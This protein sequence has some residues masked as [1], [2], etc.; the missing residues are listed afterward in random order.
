MTLNKSYRIT[1]ILFLLMAWLSS[2]SAVLAQ[3]PDDGQNCW[4]CHRQPNLSGV[5]GTRAEIDQCLECHS[6][7]QVDEW[8]AEG[9][10]PVY[11]DTAHYADTLH[12]GIACTA[13][14]SDV[15]R[16]PHHAE[17]PV[18]CT[19]C[20]ATLLTH[21]QMGAPHASTDC[22]AC[23]WADLPAIQDSATGRVVVAGV[24]AEGVVLD[25]T[26]HAV[27]TDPDCDTCHV[28]GNS[29]GAPA[30][31][32]PAR[33]VICMACHDASPTVSVAGI[34]GAR[35]T[36]YGAIIGLLVFVVGMG[37]NFSIY[38]RGEIPG[39]PGLTVMQKLSYLA[40]EL[41]KLVFSRRVLRFIGGIIADGILLRRVLQESVSRWVMHALIYL[42][43][44]ARF[45]LGLLTWLGE[46]FW[47]A[48]AWTQTLANKDAPSVAF[49]YDFLALLVILGVLVALY[50]RFVVRVPQLRTGGQDKLA[51]FLLGALFLVGIITEG[52]RLL[53]AATPPDV[54]V[55]SFLGYGVA[56]LLRPLNL[57][58]TSV[59]PLLWYL[60]AWL[61]AAIIAYLPFSKFMHILAGPF[62]ASL[63]TAIKGTN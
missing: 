54:A 9:R 26:A 4:A 24:D 5:A 41:V 27:V 23:H 34:G 50:R 55:Y 33:S 16:N 12:G 63:D 47:P 15:A 7:P 37:A 51:I 44:L 17:K 59:Y 43:F 35:V 46:L 61:A 40:A 31:V 29:I 2:T 8:A 11:I 48:S 56:L 10:T 1:I 52:V 49:A 3:G 28:A 60:H 32:L 21:V 19:D 18:A 38:L 62:I 57:L 58:W 36:D 25:R 39:H 13:C 30:V 6:D 42:P 14:H 53:S 45:L 20:H 22:A